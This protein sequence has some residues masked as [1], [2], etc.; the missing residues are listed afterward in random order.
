MS[1]LHSLKLNRSERPGFTLIELIVVISIIAIISAVVFVAIDIPKRQHAARNSRRWT[2]VTAILQAVKSY[3]ADN[4]GNF[5]GAWGTN[6]DATHYGVIGT[7]VTCSTSYSCANAA[8]VGFTMA[9]TLCQADL[10]TGSP[11]AAY[12]KSI[13]F[14]PGGTVSA[15]TSVDTKYWVT[16]DANGLLSIG[17][18]NAEGE[19]SNGVGSVPAISVSG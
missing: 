15:G 10:I 4:Q 13:P 18:C 3:Q 11:L 7:G 5:P 9:A 17:T 8:P 16:K 1:T 2:D 14:D 19:G 6:I 12:L